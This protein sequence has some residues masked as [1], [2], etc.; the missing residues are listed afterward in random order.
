MRLKD[1]FKGKISDNLLKYIPSSYE[2]IGSRSK[3][4]AIVEIP[5][6][7]EHLKY[8]I[9]EAIVKINKHVKTVLRK[10]SGRQGVF[11]I[12]DYEILWGDPD[13]EVVHK[14]YGYLIKLD[15]RKVYFSAREG[16]E[17]MRIARQ[18]RPG[19]VVMYMF[20]GVGPFAIAIAKHQPL[21]RKIIAAEI[22][23]DAY[24]Y[25]LENIKLNKLES[26]VEAYLG[27]VREICPKWYGTCDR[28]LMPLPKGAHT[29]LDVA[30]SCL[31]PEGGVV[32]FYHWSHENTL[33]RDAEKIVGEWCTR[34]GYKYKI[35]SK[36]IVLPY[37]PRVYKVCLDF[38]AIRN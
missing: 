12:R 2:I 30:L 9:A 21:V 34:L 13:T 11:R 27:D 22:N 4:V 5:C 15:P 28:V 29:F 7:V 24:R 25:L 17:R 16:T 26:V 33:F 20:A 3:A 31:K 35:L 1:Y 8:E 19:E 18:V 10:K 32:H 23:P 6:E 14:E 36:R 38:F 37:A